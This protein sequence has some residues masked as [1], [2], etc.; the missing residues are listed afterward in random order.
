MVG[1]LELLE[2]IEPSTTTLPKWD[3]TT[4]LQQLMEPDD[5]IEP[6]SP[7]YK[8]GVLPIERNG[9]ARVSNISHNAQVVKGL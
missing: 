9:P 5:G 3:S 6:S 1:L 8:G 4:E 7:L 2:G